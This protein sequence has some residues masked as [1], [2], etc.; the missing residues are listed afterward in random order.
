MSQYRTIYL[1]NDDE[2]NYWLQD[3]F[4]LK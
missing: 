4:C 1:D 2:S 3:T